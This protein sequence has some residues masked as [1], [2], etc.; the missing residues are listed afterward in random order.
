[1]GSKAQSIPLFVCKNFYA[2]SLILPL[3]G[4]FLNSIEDEIDS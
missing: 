2:D 4:I 1:M 3:A